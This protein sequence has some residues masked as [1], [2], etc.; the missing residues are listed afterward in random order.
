MVDDKRIPYKENLISIETR[1]LTLKIID[2]ETA[3]SI[4][5][6]FVI[7]GAFRKLYRHLLS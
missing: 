1:G 7:R 2:V 6:S 4:G 3:L 5:L